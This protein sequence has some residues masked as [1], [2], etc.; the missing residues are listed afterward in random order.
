MA[1]TTILPSQTNA[2]S[3]LNQTLFDALREDLDYLKAYA[4]AFT[5]LDLGGSV[6]IIQ[7][8]AGT[9]IALGES[10]NLPAPPSG[11]KWRLELVIQAKKSGDTAKLRFRLHDKTDTLLQY[12]DSVA[13]TLSWL[14]Y[15]LTLDVTDAI[16]GRVCVW[17][18]ENPVYFASAR[19]GAVRASLVNVIG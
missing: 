16:W 15:T 6:G 9:E 2:D 13:L 17:F 3:P 11:K 7:G 14:D 18:I 1:W 4:D 19:N 8:A 10:F 5:Y 12:K